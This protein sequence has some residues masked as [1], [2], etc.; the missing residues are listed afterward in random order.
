MSPST[1]ESASDG[2]TTVPPRKSTG[3]TL[4][5]VPPTR[6]NGAIAIVTSSPRKSAHVR[7]FTTFHVT[8][9]WVSMMPFGSPVVPEV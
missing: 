3:N 4:T 1:S 8:F 9:A 6:K 7:K 2:T 5:P